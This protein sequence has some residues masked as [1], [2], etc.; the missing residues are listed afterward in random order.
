MP[1]GF[2]ELRITRQNFLLRIAE[3]FGYED[4]HFESAEF[5]RVFCV[6]S[7]DKRFA[8]DVC[9]P[10]MIEYL[11]TNRDLG[12]EIEGPALALAF[13]K[14]LSGTEIE[15]NLGRLLQVR[16]HLPDYLFTKA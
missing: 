6:R 9:N 12:I 1:A 15:N 7:K 5:S 4:I 10:Q 2:P 3:A 16:L 8:Y 14:Q 13:A 11:L